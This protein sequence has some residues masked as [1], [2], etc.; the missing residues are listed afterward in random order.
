MILLLNHNLFAQDRQEIK[1]G[2]SVSACA[3]SA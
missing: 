3:A 1:H 2:Y